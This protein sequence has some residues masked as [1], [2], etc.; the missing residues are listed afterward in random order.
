MNI[1]VTE[2]AQEELKK[3]LDKKGSESK[4]VRIYI[5]GVGWGGPS[6]GLALDEQKD[7]DDVTKIGDYTYLVEKDLLSTYG[8]FNVDYVNDWLRKGFHIVPIRGGSTCS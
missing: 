2:K 7:G 3:I 4:S 6:F 8:T 5:A 1:N